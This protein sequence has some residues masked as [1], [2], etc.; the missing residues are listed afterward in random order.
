MWSTMM[1]RG[2]GRTGCGMTGAANGRFA[3]ASQHPP[4]CLGPLL[5]LSLSPGTGVAGLFV[6]V[7]ATLRPQDVAREG[8]VL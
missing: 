4:N 3:A 8:I 2:A 1:M 6:A 7:H 5:S